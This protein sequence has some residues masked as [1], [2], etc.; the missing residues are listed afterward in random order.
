MIRRELAIFLIV[1]CLTVLLDFLSYR[2]LIWSGLLGTSSAKAVGFLVGTVFAYFANRAWTF[3]QT[4]HAPGSAWRFFL[5]YA[6]TLAAN[7]SVNAAALALMFGVGIALQAAFVLATGVSTI[8]NF[9]GMK[10]F[11][12]KSRAIV[13]LM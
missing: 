5:L 8:L 7:V 4:V 10:F 1:G 6:V 13:E 2:G 3:R 11:V 9:L 12:F